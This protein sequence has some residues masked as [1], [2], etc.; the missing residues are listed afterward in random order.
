MLMKCVVQEAKSPVK[1]LVRQC[2]AE[3]FNSGNKRLILI[4]MFSVTGVDTTPELGIY[5]PC[6]ISNNAQ[7]L[8]LLTCIWDMHTSISVM[9]L[10]ILWFCG[11]PQSFQTIIRTESQKRNHHHFHI[12]SKCSSISEGIYSGLQNALA[13]KPQNKKHNHC[14][15]YVPAQ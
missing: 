6:F 8:T 1:Y 7:M 12:L 5:L 13:N 11:S 3:E 10:M 9:T 2:C 15:P 4:T 14:F